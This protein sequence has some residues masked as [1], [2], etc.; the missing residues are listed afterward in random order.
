MDS[1]SVTFSYNI[2]NRPEVKR[3][4]THTA[5]YRWD[6]I[7]VEVNA[8]EYFSTHFQEWVKCSLIT[9]LS[10]PSDGKLNIQV[11]FDGRA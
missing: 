1:R 8:T 11:V 9:R 4:Y 6:E 2:R 7:N 5:G 10:N 3:L